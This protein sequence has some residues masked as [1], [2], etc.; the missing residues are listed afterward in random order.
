MQRKAQ[1][2]DLN[3]RQMPIK[4]AAPPQMPKPGVFTPFNFQPQMQQQQIPSFQNFVPT[5]PVQHK[6]M[7]VVKTEEPVP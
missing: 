5:P 7:R 2:Q 6:A 3:I 1:G 4:P